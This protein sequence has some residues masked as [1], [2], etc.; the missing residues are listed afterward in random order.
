MAGVTNRGKKRL[1]QILFRNED[2]PAHYYVAL[3]TSTVVPTSDTNTIS[4][5]TQIATGNGYDSGGYQLTSGSADF[6]FI[7]E[8]DDL[9]KAII[10]LK[11]ISWTASGGNI[12][13]SGNGARYACL[14][15]DNATIAN[16]AII[17][18][19]DLLAD[20]Y[21]SSGNALIIQNLQIDL[22]E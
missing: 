11:N 21:V 4:D 15:D 13:S 7:A 6:D 1:L 2:V 22:G 20:R 18:F 14:T 10:Q 3:F 16:R 19:W 5:L 9:N 12:P 8:D 17:A